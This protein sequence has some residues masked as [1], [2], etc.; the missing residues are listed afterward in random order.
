MS[1][2]IKQ[3]SDYLKRG[4]I[5]SAKEALLSLIRKLINT[6]G[7]TPKI[8]PREF[9]QLLKMEMDIKGVDDFYHDILMEIYLSFISKDK[10]SYNK[11]TLKEALKEYEET[12]KTKKIYT[13]YK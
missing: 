7:K 10:A 1:K 5:K 13:L 2:E 12:G 4:E 6:E 9:W 8:T 3:I 11:E